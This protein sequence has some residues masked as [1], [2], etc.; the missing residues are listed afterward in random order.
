VQD[1]VSFD[2]PATTLANYTEVRAGATTAEFVIQI[3]QTI[4]SGEKPQQVS[5]QSSELPAIYSHFAIPKLDLEAFLTARITDW[6]KLNLL[7]GV[8]RI[9]FE[10]TY[11]TEAYLDPAL[12]DDTLSL[13]L[14]RDPKVVIS[15]ELLKDFSKSRTIGLNREKTIAWEI[16][17]K[18]T[19]STPARITLEDQVPI[20]MDKDIIVKVEDISGAAHNLETGKLTWDL[21]LA[22]GESKT[23]RLV[24]TVKHPKNK[25]V[26]GI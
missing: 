21:Q 12:T 24:F 16:K 1:E 10:G 20:S 6:E 19:K 5:V 14:G 18:N 8:A 15:R 4:K 23:L 2:A 3:P 26:A 9:F 13:S 11:V 22:P 25:P 17:V 7:P